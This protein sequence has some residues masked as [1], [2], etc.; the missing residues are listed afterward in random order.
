MKTNLDLSQLDYVASLAKA[1]REWI[2][3]HGHPEK[4]D[5]VK[6]LELVRDF[7]HTLDLLETVLIHFEIKRS[8][9]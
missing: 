7:A 5:Q 9:F 1:V 4:Y 3:D 2:G 6:N 8:S